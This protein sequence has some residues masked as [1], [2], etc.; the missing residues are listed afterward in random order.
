M[1]EA[2]PG[3]SEDQPKVTNQPVS[4]IEV[5]HASVAARYKSTF[6]RT[7]RC[8]IPA[9]G[10][11]LRKNSLPPK[12]RWA[13]PNA[14]ANDPM[15]CHVQ[16]SCSAVHTP[17]PHVG[18]LM[19]YTWSWNSHRDSATCMHKG[20]LLS[21]ALLGAHEASSRH[22]VT[23]SHTC[24]RRSHPFCRTASG[25]RLTAGVALSTSAPT[26]AG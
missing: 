15:C 18:R 23:Q 5:E 13:S 12:L 22:Q 17:Y 11:C 7:S 20:H 2:R 26:M 16:P 10:L 8:R 24:S 4:S 9:R 21:A 25:D 3:M 14:S 1:L 19:P 6:S